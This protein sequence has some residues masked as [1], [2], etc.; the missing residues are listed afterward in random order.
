[1]NP[2]K[3]KPL[4][5]KVPNELGLDPDL[6]FDIFD[7]YWEN[8]RK[9][10]TSPT[11]S[12]INIESLGVLEIKE[13]TLD[14]TIAKYKATLDKL[15]KTNFSKY[16]RYQTLET[17]LVMLEKLKAEIAKTL[18]DKKQFKEKKNGKIN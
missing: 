18:D 16:Q 13:K 9:T 7:F 6:V 2:K 8:V 3:I 4:L 10:I 12:R 15:D 14:R 5:D 17:R 1:L 11:H